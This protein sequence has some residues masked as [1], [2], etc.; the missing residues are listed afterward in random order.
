MDNGGMRSYP[1]S[2]R[3]DPRRPALLEQSWMAAVTPTFFEL[4]R[5]GK[6]QSNVK[7][8]IPALGRTLWYKRRNVIKLVVDENIRALPFQECAITIGYFTRY[9]FEKCKLSD[10][11]DRLTSMCVD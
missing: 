9:K 6:G 10:E 5:K 3:D 8:G 11:F 4:L 2:A 7:S 1:R